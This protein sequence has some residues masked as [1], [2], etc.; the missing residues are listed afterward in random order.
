LN[1]LI[2]IP[3]YNHNTPCSLLLNKLSS[4]DILVIDDGSND[5]FKFENN[6]LNTKIIRN[7]VNRGKGYCIKKAAKYAKSKNYSHILTIDADLQHSPKF[8]DDFLKFNKHDFVYGKRNFNKNMPISRKISNYLTSKVTSYIC[9][10]EIS[11][12][13]CGYR[14]YNLNLFNGLKSLEDGYQFETE[15]L[16]KKINRHSLVSYVDITTVY[17]KNGSSISN[18]H[19]TMKFIILIVR[20]ILK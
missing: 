9:N 3:N 8:I 20:N 19:D 4:Y 2:V 16:L 5:I 6:Q 15:I 17:N 13:Q 10:S 18:I 7:S 14:L 1:T 12:S 11:D